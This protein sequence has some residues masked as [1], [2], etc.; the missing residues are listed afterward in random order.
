MEEKKASTLFEEM[1]DDVSSYV[2][3]T[4][5][6]AKLEAFEKLAKGSAVAAHS[7]ILLFI[8]LFVLLLVFVTAGLYLGELLQNMWMGFG[9]VSLFNLLL[10]LIIMSAG[11][12]IK[13]SIT[14]KIISFLMEKNDDDDK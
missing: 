3:N 10:L 6:I 5:E 1:R 8:A 2:Q 13:S 7:L 12:K 11:K 9:I 4:I 14:N